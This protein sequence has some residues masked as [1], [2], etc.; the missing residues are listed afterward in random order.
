MLFKVF[1]NPGGD[2]IF[3]VVLN[4]RL[5]A[6]NPGKRTPM[7]LVIKYAQYMRYFSVWFGST[8]ALTP[9]E[10]KKPNM[11]PNRAV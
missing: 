5:A 4:G 6:K 8:L 3:F 7:L 11:A 1:S 9:E 2:D 10:F